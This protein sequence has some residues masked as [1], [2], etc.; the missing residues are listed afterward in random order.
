MGRRESVSEINGSRK[1]MGGGI[2]QG[3]EQRKKIIEWGTFA[4][5]QVKWTKKKNR[6]RRTKRYWKSKGKG[7]KSGQGGNVDAVRR[8]QGS[9]AARAKSG[10]ATGKGSADGGHV[11]PPTDS[12]HRT[13]EGETALKYG[14]PPRT[15]GGKNSD[16]LRRECGMSK[17]AF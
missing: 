14:A 17:V 4:P 8:P 2:R 9:K 6:R 12:M 15:G 5:Q 10:T 3:W 7:W 11:V 13:G 1:G 16:E